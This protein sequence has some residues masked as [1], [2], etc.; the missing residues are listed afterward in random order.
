[1]KELLT[2]RANVERM[3]GA[4]EQERQKENEQARNPPVR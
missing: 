3:Q 1:M 2:I 4:N